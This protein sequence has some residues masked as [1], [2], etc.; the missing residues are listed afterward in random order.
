MKRVLLLHTGGTLGMAGGRPDV[1]RPGTYAEA[2]LERIPELEKLAQIDLEIF[3]N[4]DSSD[5]GPDDWVA[6]AKRV[7]LA[8]G[9]VDGVVI[10]HGTDT[11]AYTAS[12]L[13]Y[14]LSGLD[15]PVILTG[16]QRPL[17]EVR[18]DARHNLIGAVE[19]A[20]LPLCEVAIFFGD[21]LLR[22][23]AA[24]KVEVRR[25]SAFESPNVAPLA[26]AGLE[27]EVAP[28]ARRLPRRVPFSLQADFENRVL[29]LKLVPGLPPAMLL[30]ATAEAKGVVLE[31]FGSGNIPGRDGL[32]LLDCID[33]L[34]KRRIP[35]VISSQAL[36][37]GVD[38]GLYERGA[39]AL[40]RGAIPAGK[41][42]FEAAVTKLMWVL[43][44]TDD[45]AEVRKLMQ[46]DISGELSA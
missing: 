35:V 27:L 13:T 39:E 5:L 14:A 16:S 1:L 7:S 11:M 6:L 38:L 41:M 29:A 9:K 18:T 33:V 34:C 22:G 36:R 32:S 44:Q 20:T 30:A 17:A 26:R 23:V 2:L 43:K 28:H 15:F 10:I 3:S 37:G 21:H 25:Y 4:R 8:R 24:T 19:A 31:A 42:T 45:P 40:Q 46:C 12:A